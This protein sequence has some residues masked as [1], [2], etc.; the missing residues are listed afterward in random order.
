MMKLLVALVMGV[1]SL[2][3]AIPSHAAAALSARTSDPSGVKVVVTPEVLDP[4]AKVWEFEI[5]MDTHTKPLKEDLMQAAVLV[6]NTGR[7]YAPAEWQGDAPG[8]HHRKGILRFTAPTEMPA[9]VELRIDGI[10]GA[11]TRSFRWDLK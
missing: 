6:D 7:R 10:G 1:G 3:T 8:G 11:A 9:A 2:G 4:A 5:V